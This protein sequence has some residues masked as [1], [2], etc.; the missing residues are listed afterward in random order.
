MIGIDALNESNAKLIISELVKSSV[1]HFLI[2]PGSRS[3]P[4][5]LAASENPLAKTIVHFDER[6]LAFAGLGIAKASENPACLICT[7]G[8]ALANFYPAIIEAS[9]SYTPLI[10]LSSDRPSELRDVGANQSIDQVKMFGSYLRWEVDLLISDPHLP[11][12]F[13]KGA[14]NQACF[15]AKNSP[16]GP[17]LI[18][19]MIREPLYIPGKRKSFKESESP[20]PQTCYVLTD[21]TLREDD[22]LLIANNL[23]RY[24]K[25]IIIVG[26]LPESQN[27]E[28]IYSLAMKLQWP[29]FADSLSGLRSGGRDSSL[30]PF[31][32]H[33][34]QATYSS[35]KLIPDA[36]LYLGGP[37]VSKTLSKWLKTFAPE[38][39]YHVANFP[40]RQDPSHQVTDRLEMCPTDFCQNVGYFLKARSV[41]IWLSLWKEYSL[42][43]EEILRTFFEDSIQL[44][45]PHTLF[46]ILNESTELYSLFFS[47]SLPIRYA[48]TFFFPEKPSAKVFSN[49]GASGIDGIIATSIGVGIGNEKPL[50]AFIGDLAFLHDINSLALAKS[51]NLPII[52]VILNNSGGGLFHFLPISE[53]RK[54][55][56]TFISAKH[57]LKMAE[58]AKAFDIPY[59]SPGSLSDYQITLKIALENP[60]LQIIEVQTNADENY[61]FHQQI[62]GYIRKRMSKG[63]KVGQLYTTASRD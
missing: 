39:F 15:R 49:R 46:S 6:G 62:D 53:N 16:P 1:R 40:D 34:L 42:Q 12:D 59:T 36:V 5:T 31:Y 4:I 25:G 24:E 28:S 3:T 47:A 60:S 35:E 33:L 52:F 51:L 48:D 63:K 43:I 56:D 11:K 27:L 7:S 18:N 32:N 20:L 61:L 2:S 50:I 55:M 14:I 41:S 45:E 29:I 26:D 9:T 58:F 10:I 21:R 17:V 19:I 54:F 30:I 23:A 57:S 13:L 37:I 44:S 8:T 38:K 22:S